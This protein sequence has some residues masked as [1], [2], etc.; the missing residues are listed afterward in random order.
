MKKLNTD[1]KINDKLKFE[2]YFPLL[3]GHK[4]LNQFNFN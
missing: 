2:G 4:N 1:Y 3:S